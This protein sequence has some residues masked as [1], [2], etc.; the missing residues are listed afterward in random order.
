LAI[1]FWG[2]K[3]TH[4]GQDGVYMT[5]HIESNVIRAA[6]GYTSRLNH[7]N[8]VFCSGY[9]AMCWIVEILEEKN[10][11]FFGDNSIIS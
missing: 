5:I 1:C 4:F 6:D 10:I 2:Q 3:N 11:I 8:I 9:E 7:N